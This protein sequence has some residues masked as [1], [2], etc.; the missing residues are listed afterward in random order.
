MSLTVRQTED[1]ILKVANK[2]RG[3]YRPPQ[4]RKVML[5]MTVLRRFDC[6]LAP[7]R[8]AVV[9]AAKEMEGQEL[10]DEVRHRRLAKAAGAGE[11][12]ALYNTSPFTFDLLLKDPDG[13]ATNMVAM[14]EGFSPVAR[15]I[16]RRF[17]FEAQIDKLDAGGKLFEIVKAFKGVDLEPDAFDNLAMGTLFEGLIRKFNEQANEEA[18]DHF[19]PREVIRLM[20]NLLYTDEEAI[21]T[22]GTFRT[23]Y[24]PACGTGGML[25]ESE[26]YLR[27]H[28][29]RINLELYGQEYND[30]SW[31]ICC[32]DMLIKGEDVSRIAFADTLTDDAHEGETFHYMKANPPFGVEWKTQA[33]KVKAEAKDLGMR[34]RFGAGL[35]AVNDGSLLFLQHMIDKMKPVDEGGSRI[36]VVFN[37]S[38]LFS[39]G[40]GGGESNIRRW[41]I[42]NDWLEA[43]IALPDQLFYNTG[44]STYVWIVTNRK[45]EAR[46]GRVQLIDA[47]RHYAKMREA[48]EQGRAFGDK[49]NLMTEAQIREVT[50]LY[51]ANQDGLEAEVLVDGET[52]RRVV[53]K[54]LPN[55]AFGFLKV[56]VERPLR[57]R[58]EVTRDRLDALPDE[59]AFAKLAVSK[60]K[61]VFER[62]QEIAVGRARQQAIL[63]VLETL[64]DRQWRDRQ[65]FRR[66]LKA[67][68]KAADVSYTG[69]QAAVEPGLSERDPGA[70]P[71]LKAGQPEPDPELRDTETVPL[72]TGTPLPLPMGYGPKPD[73]NEL[74]EMMAPVVEA[75]M[76]EEVLPHVPDAWADPSKTKVGYEIPVGRQFY[77]YEP[78][79][80]V[81]VIEDEIA[82]LEAEIAG[83]VRE[84][85]A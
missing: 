85:A 58:F 82:K 84:V 51:A 20:A 31:A 34:G 4:Y 49:R 45:A 41:I 47:T 26:R 30:E 37:G 16:F 28:N 59:P 36:A 57:L 75:Y 42:E 81:R 50:E 22:P 79:R 64:Q 39:G 10:P 8:D 32:A 76:A 83:L 71:C 33:D 56:T 40:A 6:V 54:I 7:T 61:D 9:A 78:P 35:P 23:V 55:E 53:T 63:H 62:D 14:I 74:E 5:P 18:G 44:I 72:P 38:P 69:V 13:L 17:E 70:E 77:V 66:D 29:D 27:A 80:P 1:L 67:A 65:A 12:Q 25:S 15:E 48:H 24:D 46:R 2:L 73:S 21:H 43:V 60:R 68:F 19:T 11:R 3:P 52:K